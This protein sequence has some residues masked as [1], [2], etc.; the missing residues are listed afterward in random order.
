MIT[1]LR[2][3][4]ACAVGVG[5]IAALDAA[6]ESPQ[7]NETEALWLHLCI[8]AADEAHAEVKR[9]PPIVR[10]RRSSI[11]QL[12]EH[13]GEDTDPAPEPE[14]LDGEALEQ[15]ARAAAAAAFL[16]CMPPLTTRRRIRA[17]I[18]CVAVA[19]QRRYVTAGDA[20]KLLY[21]AQTALLANPKPAP[22]KGRKAKHA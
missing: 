15:A 16:G 19:M 13:L 7:R 12:L 5:I 11:D 18:A 10:P 21:A 4:Q 17:Y 8:T 1:S 20:A 3:V 14:A 2:P 22:R 6:A 9:N